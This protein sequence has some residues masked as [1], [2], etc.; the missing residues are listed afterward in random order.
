MKRKFLT[1]FLS[2][3]AAVLP[4]LVQ[5]VHAATPT[6]AQAINTTLT[7]IEVPTATVTENKAV[8]FDSVGSETESGQAYLCTN[9][10]VLADKL[11]LVITG[12]KKADSVYVVA[13][14]TLSGANELPLDKRLKVSVKDAQV[15][16]ASGIDGPADGVLSLST[17]IDLA[18]L[19]TKGIVLATGSKLYLQTLVIPPAAIASGSIDWAKVRF[20]ELDTIVVDKCV[21]STYGTPY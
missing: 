2:G 11:S 3:K 5:Q 10:G 6:F 20:S 19:Q 15:V 17:S 7:Q 14:P 16:L 12:L 13:S 4:S 9:S 1:L 21:T 8:R 18:A